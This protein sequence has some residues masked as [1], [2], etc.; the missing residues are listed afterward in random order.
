[1]QDYQEVFGQALLAL[2]LVDDLLRSRFRDPL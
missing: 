2:G 1:M